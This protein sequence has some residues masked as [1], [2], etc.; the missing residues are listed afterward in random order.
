MN[1]VNTHKALDIVVHVW[2][3][4]TCRHPPCRS[5]LFLSCCLLQ[6][7]SSVRV[8][9]TKV[10]A[11][12]SPFEATFSLGLGGSF[13]T[14]LFELHMQAA[15]TCRSLCI[16]AGDV[17]SFAG[18]GAGTAGFSS[19][20]QDVLGVVSIYTMSVTRTPEFTSTYTYGFLSTASKRHTNR[21]PEL[22]S[23]KRS[24]YMQL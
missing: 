21:L 6:V 19:R 2:S 20:R 1:L 9:F 23:I 15:R 4:K 10:T 5:L 17:V 24:C 18:A 11:G 13:H 12:S 14:T 8:E 22:E 7:V 3:S 16:L